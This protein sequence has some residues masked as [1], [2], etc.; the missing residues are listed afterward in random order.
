MQDDIQETDAVPSADI[1]TEIATDCIRYLG[2]TI[3][4]ID[5]LTIPEIELMLNAQQLKE[6]DK[7]RDQHLLAW[8]TV[9]AGA[10]KKDGKPVYKRFD[11]FFDYEKELKRV[12]KRQKPDNKFS[13][14]SKHLKEKEKCNRK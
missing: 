1:Y 7:M 2:L 14:L 4:E 6:V 13:N 10:T 3:E 12:E 9:S 11:D 5:R 8:L